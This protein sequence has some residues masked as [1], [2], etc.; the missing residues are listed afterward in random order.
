[1]QD[2]VLDLYSRC[3]RDRD[4]DGRLIGR[5]LTKMPSGADIGNVFRVGDSIFASVNPRI[6]RAARNA[7]VNETRGEED[8][9]RK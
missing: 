6:V 2:L 8:E 5:I 9:P 1:M 4:N 3:Q 7:E